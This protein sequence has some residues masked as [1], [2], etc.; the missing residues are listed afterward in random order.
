MM[1]LT[2]KPNQTTTHALWMPI[3]IA[4]RDVAWPEMQVSEQRFLVAA[5]SIDAKSVPLPLTGGRP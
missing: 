4:R 3:R 1:G 5:G 2:S